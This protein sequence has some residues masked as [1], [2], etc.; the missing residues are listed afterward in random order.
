MLKMVELRWI[1]DAEERQAGC[2]I[3][4]AHLPYHLQG[5]E[6]TLLLP[7]IRPSVPSS[8]RQPA[9]LAALRLGV[10]A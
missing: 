5:P 3:C 4:L 7:A 8:I 2:G 1:P 6:G 10:V 9:R